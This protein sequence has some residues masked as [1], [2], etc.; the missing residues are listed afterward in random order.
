MTASL[1][2]NIWAQLGWTWSDHVETAPV[3]DSNRHQ[4]RTE[5]GDGNGANQAE[6]VWHAEGE[7]LTSGAS[8][9]LDLEALSV[10]L[11]GDTL[12]I[13][14][15]G[16][17]ALSI[18]NYAASDGYLLVGDAAADAWYAP[19]GTADDRVKVVPGG[20]MLLAN[21]QEGWPVLPGQTDLKIEAVGGDVTYDIAILGTTTESGSSSGS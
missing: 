1:R 4:F 10:S 8:T 18:V 14:L 15:V 6:A 16:V 2:S 3:T 17:R 19:L 20:M 21:P 12:T 11:F 5:L 13:S 7:T 9:T